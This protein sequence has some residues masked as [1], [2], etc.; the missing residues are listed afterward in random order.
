MNLTLAKLANET[1][2][3][4]V[5]DLLKADAKT[6][7]KLE[8]LKETNASLHQQLTVARGDACQE[9]VFHLRKTV[10]GNQAVIA[11]QNDKI[12]ELKD[13]LFKAESRCSH[14]EAEFKDATCRLV[15]YEVET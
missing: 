4:L 12:E 14:F 5:E 9:T 15:K 13:A 10:Q 6:E 3:A 1:L 11:E 7:E 8:A 2:I